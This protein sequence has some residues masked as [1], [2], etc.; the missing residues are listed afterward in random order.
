MSAFAP[1][2]GV[3]KSTTLPSGAARAG[4]SKRTL[5]GLPRPL[6]SCKIVTEEVLDFGHVPDLATVLRTMESAVLSG[7]FAIIT[8]ALMTGSFADRMR[9]KPYLI[10]LVLWLVL[11]GLTGIIQALVLNPLLNRRSLVNMGRPRATHLF[12]LRGC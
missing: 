10:F 5:R 1:A 4:Y 7:M 8:P 3:H 6:A 9:V 11:L 12:I 2:I